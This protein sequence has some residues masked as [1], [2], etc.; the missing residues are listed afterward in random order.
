MKLAWVLPSELNVFFRATPDGR[1]AVS[2]LAAD[3]LVSGK[4]A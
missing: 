1:K 2:H 4:L 3:G